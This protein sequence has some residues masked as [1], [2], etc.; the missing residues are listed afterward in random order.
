MFVYEK[1]LRDYIN[2]SIVILE[3]GTGDLRW[4]EY[5]LLIV[6]PSFSKSEVL[7]RCINYF[8]QLKLLMFLRRMLID[9]L[10]ASGI[11]LACLR[12]WEFSF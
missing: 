1:Y 8:F 4:E 2:N 11:W 6:Y 5:L 3:K 9:L 7:A 12:S 10:K